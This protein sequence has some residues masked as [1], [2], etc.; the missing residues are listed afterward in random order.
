MASKTS[1]MR[2]RPYT[3]TPLSNSASDLSAPAAVSRSHQMS[4]KY[5]NAV[6]NGRPGLRVS[7]SVPLCEIGNDSSGQNNGLF[8]QNSAGAFYAS[9][10]S[11]SPYQITLATQLLSSTTATIFSKSSWISPH[12]PLL[13]LAFDR[14]CIDSLQFQ[15]EP[16][17]T[18]TFNDRLVFAWTDDPAH[19][20][21]APTVTNDGITLPP[22]Q[23]ETLVTPDSVAFM[24]WKQW[25]LSVPVSKE[26]RYLFDLEGTGIGPVVGANVSRFSEFGA[27]NCVCS[28]PQTV[29]QVYGILYANIQLCLFDPV[30]I[31]STSVIPTLMSHRMGFKRARV[32]TE[33]KEEKRDKPALPFS[34][35]DLEPVAPHDDEFQFVTP[36]APPSRPS[37]TSSSSILRSS[38]SLK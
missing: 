9:T 35:R 20:F 24:P 28:V 38:S 5:T 33:S 10:A 21:L 3:R 25:K 26:P 1:R 27:I 4:V 17:A 19:P 7:A 15:Y 8:I 37:S 16:Q 2:S 14:Y 23:L 11:V 34:V 22:T 32:R 13:A 29:A 36:R 12:V 31:V 30:P 6:I 18:S